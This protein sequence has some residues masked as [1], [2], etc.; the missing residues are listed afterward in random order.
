M[1]K[2]RQLYFFRLSLFALVL[3]LAFASS[4]VS[5]QVGPKIWYVNQLATGRNDGSSWPNAFTDLQAAL[6]AAQA[7]DQIWVAKGIYIPSASLDRS[8]SFVLKEGL[9]LYGGFAGNETRLSQRNFEAQLTILSGDLAGDDQSDSQAIVTDSNQIVGENSLH[10]VVARQLSAAARLDGFVITGGN[11]NQAH[12]LAGTSGGGMLIEESSPTLVNLTFAG[13]AA[14][15]SGGAIF[16]QQSQPSLNNLI[17]MGNHAA[18]YGGAIFNK[19]S[20]PSLETAT[21]F[22]NSAINGGAIF[23]RDKS[24]PLLSN[25]VFSSNKAFNAGGAIYNLNSDPQINN[26]SFEANSALDGAGIY[27]YIGSNPSLNAISFLGNSASNNG[28]GIFNAYGSSPMLTNLVFSGNSALNRGGGM[29]NED[30]SNPRLVNVSFSGNRAGLAGGGMFNDYYSNPSIQNSLF[31]NNSSSLVNSSDSQPSVSY[32][33]VQGCFANGVWEL[34]CGS[35]A[36]GN[37]SDN[38]PLFLVPVDPSSAPTSAGDLR[39]QATSPMLD[40]GNS[41]AN[42][43]ATDLDGKPRLF[44]AAID[45]GSY[46]LERYRLSTTIVGNGTLSIHPS[47]AWYA[48]DQTVTITATPALGWNFSAWSGDLQSITPTLSLVITSTTVLTATFSNQISAS[49]LECCQVLLQQADLDQ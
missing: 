38:D 34:S 46:E 32:S 35:N 10:V 19:A 6:A 36:G 47:A 42:P 40:Q 22:Q 25:L 45:L 3:S 18:N 1:P 15:D 21:F 9:A 13:N 4:P 14:S 17:F 27:N 5:S 26:A 28:A 29:F 2:P 12:V 30:S 7:S 23:N 8:S 33:M 49:Q 24:A 44:G 41:A 39:L 43:V 37:L 20:S 16:S 11:A 48:L 31:W